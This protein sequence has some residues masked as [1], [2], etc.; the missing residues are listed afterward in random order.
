MSKNHSRRLGQ[1]ADSGFG[2]LELLVALSI[3]TAILIAFAQ[4]FRTNISRVELAITRVETDNLARSI[5]A[6]LIS[7]TIA[8]IQRD[9]G[10]FPNLRLD[11][12]PLDGTYTGNWRPYALTIYRL[13]DK[14]PD[15][16]YEVVRLI[17]TSSR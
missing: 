12:K 14:G 17:R 6:R 8:D 16:V 5:E 9:L 7:R 15:F 2:L 11:A 4:A 13:S 1:S 10:T 3:L